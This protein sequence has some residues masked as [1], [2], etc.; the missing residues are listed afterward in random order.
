M[1]GMRHAAMTLAATAALAAS[2]CTMQSGGEDVQVSLG[3][4]AIEQD[5]LGPGPGDPVAGAGG[6]TPG[7]VGPGDLGESAAYY[8]R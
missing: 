6:I 1:S 3:S 2:G 4:D 8:Y 7:S 5:P